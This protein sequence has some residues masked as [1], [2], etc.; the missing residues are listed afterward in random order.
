MFTD[1]SRWGLALVAGTVCLVELA[2]DGSPAWRTIKRW[3]GDWDEFEEPIYEGSDRFVA[4]YNIHQGGGCNDV[5]SITMVD[6]TPRT[7]DEACAIATMCMPGPPGLD[8]EA[9]RDIIRQVAPR[10]PA[11]TMR[12]AHFS[13][14]HAAIG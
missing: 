14:K 6:T 1:D 3:S 2:A 5:S 8:I 9:A 4:T 10:R 13:S 12:A 7:W 11:A